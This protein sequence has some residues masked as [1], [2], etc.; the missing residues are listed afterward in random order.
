MEKSKILIVEDET[1]ISLYT[2]NVLES[3]GFETV[4][5]VSTGEEAIQRAGRDKP[6]VIL[7]D[8]VL[9]GE[10]DGIS[11]AEE[12]NAK[13]DIPIIYLTGH[14]DE[15]TLNRAKATEPYGYILKPVN[16]DELYSTI[17]TTIYKH[18][19]E[20]KL[21][22]SELRYRTLFDNSKSGVAI[23]RSVNSGK[24][25]HFVDF[26]KAGEKIDMLKREAVIGKSVLEIFPGIREFGLFDVLQRVWETGEPESHPIAHYL[27]NRIT[28][29]RENYV[30]KLPSGEIVAIYSDETARKQAE[31]TIRDSE[32]RYRGIVENLPLLICRFLPENGIITYVN[33]EYCSHFKKSQEELID[34]PFLDLIPEG[35]REKVKKH[36]DSLS[37][38]NPLRISVQR[39]E[40]PNGKRWLRWTDQALFDERGNVIEYQS[41]GEDI[42][43]Y[44]RAEEL[45]KS[46]LAEKEMFLK[47]I[48]HRVKNNFQIINSLINLHEINI[49]HEEFLQVLRDL[50]NRIRT[51]SIIHDKLSQTGDIRSI[52]F[53][54]YIRSISSE[55]YTIYV[56]DPKRITLH[57]DTEDVLLNMDQAITC[58]LV[59]NELLTNTFKHA[60]PKNCREDGNIW[61][62][63][64]K[65]RGNT[66][67]LVVRD[68]GPGIP[69]STD[70]K[71]ELSLGMLL[72]KNL[73]EKQLDGAVRLDREKGTKITI[74]FKKN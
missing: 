40:I 1:I 3:K 21:K 52:D 49:K 10:M 70:L 41:I 63:L 13:Y 19:L 22:E 15:A 73:T 4:S 9:S 18:N 42:T 71:E 65:R 43:E 17:V 30:Y 29:W 7:M 61:I 45:I 66:V 27:D 72:I 25:F 23:Y 68:N 47:E 35:K 14:S 31:I 5:T 32:E 2:L 34:H 58:G 57:T 51:M 54:D 26:N 28:G 56:H 39:A 8:I 60:F 37:R 12:I 48:H 50:K 44:R 16:E 46:S 6:D 33:E 20:K 59:L 36:F 11:A 24:D 38:E 53:A 64:K 69:E 74:T 55:L 62:S 67:E